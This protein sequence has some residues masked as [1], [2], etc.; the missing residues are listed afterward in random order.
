MPSAIST[1]APETSSSDN[2]EIARLRSGLA[3]AHALLAAKNDLLAVREEQVRYLRTQYDD[4]R[5]QLLKTQELLEKTQRFLISALRYRND[6][7]TPEPTNIS[8]RAMGDLSPT[9][10][11]DEHGGKRLN[12][13]PYQPDRAVPRSADDSP[14]RN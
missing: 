12:L 11:R 1:T 4:L 5:R 8:A 14:T 9:S 10:R 7:A 6:R 3:H 2:D 13:R